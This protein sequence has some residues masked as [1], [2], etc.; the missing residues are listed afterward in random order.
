MKKSLFVTAI[1]F[2]KAFDSINRLHIIKVMMKYRCDPNLIEAIAQIYTGDRT[3]IW[4]QNRKV[5]EVDVTSGIRQG[6]TCSPWLFVMVMNDI[7]EKL[8]D[9][10]IG[11][12]NEVLKIPILMFADDGLL[13]AQSKEHMRVLVKTLVGVASE[14]GMKINREKSV[15]IIFNS[16]ERIE[17][18]EEIKIDNTMKYLGVMVK[19]VRDSFKIHKENK[20]K[21]AKLFSNLTYSVIQ[22]SCNKLI[23]GKTYW[24]SVVVPAVMYGTTLVT[25]N[26]N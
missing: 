5:G 15:V 10:K 26:K 1:D 9:T 22:K 18:I 3:Q 12:R 14:I 17:K 19:N 25:W 11:F 24:E 4:F 8:I 20:I 16:E 7:I 2:A 21:T 13:M 6:C 23:I